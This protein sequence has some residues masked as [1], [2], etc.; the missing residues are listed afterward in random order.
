MSME[1]VF[2]RK[3]I[4]INLLNI[5]ILNHVLEKIDLIKCIEF[6]HL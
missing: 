5:Y 2:L 1:I 6:V 3:S 4:N